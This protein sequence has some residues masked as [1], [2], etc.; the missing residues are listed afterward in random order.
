M[1]WMIAEWRIV[2]FGDAQ[3]CFRVAKVLVPLTG[4]A[5]KAEMEA[6]LKR[7]LAQ[8]RPVVLLSP[9]QVLADDVDVFSLPELAEGL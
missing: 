1:W 5:D 6:E 4:S 9:E 2:D 7:R 8:G 3:G